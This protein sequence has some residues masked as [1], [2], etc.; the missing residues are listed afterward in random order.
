MMAKMLS[1]PTCA[2][3]ISHGIIRIPAYIDLIKAE[4][5]QCRADTSASSG[6]RRRGW[7]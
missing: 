5:D 2:A 4:V 1:G 3:P 7:C 6:R